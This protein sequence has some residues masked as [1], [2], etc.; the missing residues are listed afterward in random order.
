MDLKQRIVFGKVLTD[1]PTIEGEITE[2]D[3]VNGHVSITPGETENIFFLKIESATLCEM[4]EVGVYDHP[5]PSIQICLDL[6]YS[7]ETLPENIRLTPPN[8]SP[9]RSTSIET[10]VYCIAAHQEFENLEI[11]VHKLGGKLLKIDFSGNAEYLPHIL[12]SGHCVLEISESNEVDY[13]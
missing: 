10:M 6:G 12:I 2:F 4:P 3:I 11:H 7:A 1:K 8:Y 5:G 13:W 9:E